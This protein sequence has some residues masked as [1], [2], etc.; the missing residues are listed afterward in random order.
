MKLTQYMNEKSIT[1]ERLAELVGN[2][3]A[4]GVR[5]WMYDERV[6]RPEQMRRIAEVTKG[7]VKPN[8]FILASPSKAASI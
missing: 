6:P 8:D 2:V 7:Q 3:S 1:P 5:K 4:S